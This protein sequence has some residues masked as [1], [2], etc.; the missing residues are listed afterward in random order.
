MK[1]HVFLLALLCSASL[2]QARD[3]WVADSVPA[4]YAESLPE[5]TSPS[6]DSW[7]SALQDPTLTQL[8]SLG[9]NNSWDLLA[10][11][12]RVESARAALQRTYS[13]YY[14]QLNLSAG[15][16]KGRQSGAT[17]PQTMPASNYSYF[18]L[19]LSAS[20]E[21]DVFGKVRAQAKASKA[22]LDATRAERN[23]VLISVCASIAKTYFGL[24][25]YQ[26]Q[27]EVA[28]NHIDSQERLQQMAEDRYEAGLA[29][30]LDVAQARTLVLSTKATIPRLK[31][32][33]EGNIQ[34]LATLCGVYPE[35][36]PAGV[37]LHGELPDAVAGAPV[38]VPADLLWRRPDIVEARFNL[39][40]LAAQVGIAKKDYLP[41]LSIQG[42]I[43][44]SAHRLD[45]LFSNQSLTW[46]VAPTLSWNVFDG[47]DRKYA[48]AQAKADL[49]AAVDSYNLTVM[50][51]VSDVNSNLA[52]YAS[53]LEEIKLDREVIASSQEQLDL[54]I[55]RYK[56]GLTDFSDVAD[57]QMS[58]L[59]NRNSL[60]SA[61]GNALSDLTAIYE[62]LGGGWAPSQD[63]FE[64]KKQ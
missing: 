22:S 17:T 21:I 33:I 55:D 38:G 35:Q 43:G 23:G 14:P 12:R 28:L 54:A 27:L 48:V 45:D 34:S 64:I 36:L 2:V 18:N 32:L 58:L 56:L 44:T 53:A 51:A 62:S 13:A 8:I 52:L 40:Q 16:E 63:L 31:A 47:L 9:E 1:K 15:W 29:S 42:Q 49:E 37:R 50:Q 46:S 10:A 57:A 20:W 4:A 60:V 59:E 19:G 25:T 30:K 26:Q 3:N 6:E 61:Q 11:I 24:R 7:W 5:M 41:S 39:D